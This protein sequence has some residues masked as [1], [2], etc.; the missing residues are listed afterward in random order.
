LKQSSF[1]F[2]SVISNLQ[3]VKILIISKFA[4]IPAIQMKKPGFLIIITA[5]IIFAGTF[6]AWWLLLRPSVT[7]KGDR[8]VIF[9]PE[10]A[11][12]RQ[13][14]DSLNK[15]LDLGN[16]RLF[17]WIAGKKSYPE[18]I[19]AG[20]FVFEKKM[21]CITLVNRLRSGEQTPVRVTFNNIRTIQQLAGKVGGK[22]EAD[23]ASIAEFLSDPENYGKD[24]FSRE[25]VISIFIP[26]TYEF[27]WNTD[28]TAF[29]R[30]MLKE[31]RKFWNEARLAKARDLGLTQVE[32][33]ILASIVDD[34][35]LKASEKPAIAG[36]YIN[37]LKRGIPLQACP[38]IKFA[39][40]DF[41]I[42]RVLKKHLKIESP[43][44]TYLHK[45]FPPGPIGCP[46]VE[47]LDAVLNAEKHDYLYFVAKAD[48]SGYHHFSRTLTEHNRYAAEYQR[49]LDK[50]KIFR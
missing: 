44:N 10:G 4:P 20:R 2:L 41:T 5:T 22:I 1:S 32:V 8:V 50:R 3:V 23:S 34:E 31:Y 40:N 21:S 47:G 43:Y 13:V 24:G 36:V 45:G 6:A 42:T 30:R 46:T 14:M 15:R 25:D 49:E 27:Y 28:A 33:G 19:K 17:T 7:V 11:D 39:L 29:Y 16:P 37:R 12:F 38:T 18:H 48:F 9:I 26:D 35:V